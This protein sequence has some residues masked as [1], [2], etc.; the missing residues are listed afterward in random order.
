MSSTGTITINGKEYEVGSEVSATSRLVNFL[1]DNQLLGTHT[2]CYQG[3]CGACTV[4][5]SVPDDDTGTRR[6]YSINSC[7]VPTRACVGWEITTVEDLGNKY[8]GYHPIQQ[9]L[10]EHSGT[11]CGYC[12]PGMVMN[13]YGLTQE[14]PSWGPE[15]VEKS[16]DGN[17]CR[18]TGYRP[19]LA[20]FKSVTVQDIE[21]AAQA[22][23]PST[24][25]A[26]KGCC[27][28]KKAAATKEEEKKQVVPRSIQ[29]KD[30]NWHQP[31]TLQELYD[32]LSGFP[33][34]T[35]HTF[36]SG[37]TGQAIYSDGPF[38]EYIYTRHVAQLSNVTPTPGSLVIGANVSIS[39][40][41][42]ELGNVASTL[43][44]FTYVSELVDMWTSLGNTPVRNLGSWVGNLAMK[45][46]HPEFPSD[47]FVGLV[48][49]GATVTTATPDG[50]TT[51]HSMEELLG[52]DL[53]GERRFIIDLS[54]PT[55]PDDAAFKAYKVMPRTTNSKAD[56]NAA[57]KF[58]VDTT[59]AYTV[60]DP[61]VMAYGGINPSFVRATA[62]ET[63]LMGK[64]L[65]D[66][67]VLQAAYTSLAS[68]VV[69]DAQYQD[70]SPEYRLALAQ[71]LF[72]RAVLSIVGTAASPP[73]T[74]GAE[75]LQR[76]LSSG[77][78]TYD[79]NT[80]QY[81]L[82][83]PIPKIEAPIQISGE[84]EYITKIP[85]RPGEL[86]GMFVTAT[87]GNAAI[88]SIDP[89]PAL[90]IPGVV[91][92]VGAGDIT[93]EN[94]IVD[95][96]DPGSQLLFATDRAMYHGQPLGL[97]LA[98]DRGAA[99]A[100]R[101]A[102]QVTYGDIQTP[103]LTIDQALQNPLPPGQPDPIVM[104][105][106]QAGFAASTHIIEGAMRRDGQFHF[107]M[108]T[109]TTLA[110]PTDTGLDVFC[111]TQ[112]LSEAQRSISKVTGLKDSEVNVSCKRLG[113]AFGAKIDQCNI[114]SAATAM[115][116]LKTRRPVRVQLDLSENM[117]IIGW[118]EPYLSTYKIG[119]DDAGLLQ[120]VQATLTADSGYV[121]VDVSSPAAAIFL[122]ACY[123]CP[124]WEITPQFILTNT[125]CNTWTRTPGMLEGVTFM[126]DMMDH[127]AIQL[128]MDPLELRQKNFIPDGATRKISKDLIRIK[129]RVRACDVKFLPDAVKIPRNLLPDMITH[130]LTTA[131]VEQRKAAVTQFNQENK[132]KKRGLSIMPMLFPFIVPSIYPFPVLVSVNVGDGTITITH[133]G[134]ECGQGLNTKVAQVAA[135]ELGVALDT[136]TFATN[137][138]H[139]CANNQ[140][141]GG[142]LGSAFC[143]HNVSEACKLI[144]ARVN[145]DNLDWKSA[146]KTAYS[147]G[148]DVSQRYVNGV[149]EV[150][151][152]PVYGVGCS[153][154][155]LDI[156][157][158]QFIVQ[159][160]DL[161]EDSGRSMSP[162]VDVGQVEGG[163]VMGQGLFTSEHPIYDPTTGQKLTDG[164]WLYK[165]PYAKDI[166]VDF[167]VE[168]LHDTPN[169][170][171]V[172]YSKISQEPPVC[173]SFSV[174]MALRQAVTSARQD[175]GTTGWFQMDT[176]L[177]TDRLQRL[178]LVDASRLT[179]T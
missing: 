17:M 132:W 13:M 90:A 116:A 155:E 87:H 167:R 67:G 129:S 141:T 83:A 148:I 71:N 10:A 160:T 23:C 115:A 46:A 48:G 134:A 77:Q 8:D 80:E 34:G 171:G 136:I 128:G 36:V 57:F 151:S 147:N 78:Q 59:N 102:V 6:T 103:V 27:K 109:Q 173:L 107:H 72:Y 144:K 12:S 142:S 62:T 137:N 157:T 56:V 131:D 145:P 94:N 104:G 2:T 122:L 121:G 15:D 81:P 165:H 4:V 124:N 40:V 51:Q 9:A 130:L 92:F 26:C 106:V 79:N 133:G 114:V 55:L 32:L 93:G 112:W 21:D 3:G 166:P 85:S 96:S 29:L 105:D 98:T 54:I 7:L 5:A 143:C 164:T 74:S 86:V 163:F 108:E 84:A 97:I 139:N 53:V 178:C 49:V 39:R 110:Y 179:L 68:E 73:V 47:L 113:G 177:T 64:S 176:P 24:G 170:V 153:E 65:Q 60:L 43:S 52:L 19:I 100:G 82:G 61:P 101:A 38:T 42:S 152:Y 138:T 127:V 146:V 169:P 91:D 70:A 33:D 149:G 89:S 172:L 99:Y 31:T 25:K 11:Q 168:L 119:V 159:R 158:G 63:Y 126:E 66:E 1:H 117:T 75:P 37:N 135:Y 140:T 58:R 30:S 118:R 175:A 161:L 35:K 28:S 156:L 76:P 125:A 14:N 95:M 88:V 45:V 50:T 44:G 154:V 41:I 162:L 16:L 69:P 120:A 123:T 174:V 111:S 20:A 22:K 18:C 150:V